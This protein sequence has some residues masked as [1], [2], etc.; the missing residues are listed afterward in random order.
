M[1]Y[2]SLGVTRREGP[3]PCRAIPGAD[4]WRPRKCLEIAGRA[5]FPWRSLGYS[6][7]TTC[8]QKTMLRGRIS[9]GLL[10]R[11]IPQCNPQHSQRATYAGFGPVN[12]SLDKPNRS[13]LYV[14]GSSQKMIDKAWTLEPDNIVQLRLY[15]ADL[16][17]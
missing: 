15:R 12:S 13:L 17:S 1:P 8:S 14:P 16:D 10:R 9:Q 2:T 4:P 3:F 6:F 11:S 7:A 5:L